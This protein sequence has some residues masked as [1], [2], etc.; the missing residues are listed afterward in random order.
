M[1]EG[2]CATHQSHKKPI[3]GERERER[4]YN[5]REFSMYVCISSYLSLCR[6]TVLLYVVLNER[7]RNFA[8]KCST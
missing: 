5:W 3:I 2:L 8:R 7:L 1:T 6:H 4:S